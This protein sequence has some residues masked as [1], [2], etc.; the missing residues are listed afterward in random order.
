MP[1]GPQLQMFGEPDRTPAVD[2]AFDEGKRCAMEGGTRK[3]PYSPELP[4]FE[5]WMKGYYEGQEATIEKGGGF[6]GKPEG[7]VAH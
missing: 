4:Q 2:R 7:E 1:L 5:A 3:P 6:K